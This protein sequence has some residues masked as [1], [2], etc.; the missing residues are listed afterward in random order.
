MH[1]GQTF[2]TLVDGPI[3][4]PSSS[5]SIGTNIQGPSL[6]SNPVWAAN[7]LGRFLLYFADHKG[8]FIRLAHADELTGPWRIHEP[9]ALHIDQSG[10]ATI[11]FEI[12]DDR[13]AAIE[14]RYRETLGDAMVLDV[15]T[16][17][18]TAHV[19]SP[20]VHVDD[21]QQCLVMYFHGLETLGNQVSRVATSV[22]GVTWQAQS[23][24]LIERTYLR[25]IPWGDGLLG[26][27]MPGVL[28]RAD[29]WLGPFTEGPTLFDPDMRHCAIVATSHNDLDAGIDVYWTRVGHAP[30]RILHSR[31]DT[32]GDWSTWTVSEPTEVHRPQHAWEGAELDVAP[33]VRGAIDD[34]A[35]Q[36][37][38]PAVFEHGGERYLLHSV[39][40]ESGLSIGRLLQH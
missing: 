25:V 6:V 20:D 5:S 23:E 7:G 28:Y 31:I 3:V 21:G 12:S 38:D 37:R 16:D 39:G 34:P 13:L 32:N 10:F 9:G 27:A 36:L 22:D 29:D 18:V 24:I 30:E 17:L 15:R 14:K 1:G 19:A 2:T 26:M 11:D 8:R 40:G 35:N 33:S 4:G